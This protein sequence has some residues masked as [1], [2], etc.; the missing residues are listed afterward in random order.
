VHAEAA[1]AEHIA[2]TFLS[3]RDYA[4]TPIQTI[5]L[6]TEILRERHPDLA[7]DVDRLDRAVAALGELS[8]A[9]ARYES[10]LEWRPGDES[11]DAATLIAPP[12]QRSTA[13]GPAALAGSRG[14][15]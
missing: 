14:E 5:A 11:P 13:P 12:R 3:L 6:T 7:P 10:S 8:R 4:N 1:A 9:L 2:R 15:G